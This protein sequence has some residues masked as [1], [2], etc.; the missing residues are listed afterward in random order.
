MLSL[1]CLELS[2]RL[3]KR[4]HS[5]S[6]DSVPPCLELGLCH[7]ETDSCKKANVKCSGKEEQNRKDDRS[8]AVKGK[9]RRVHMKN[10]NPVWQHTGTSGV[11]LHVVVCD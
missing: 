4:S 3:R 9:K 2:T 1:Y 8:H 10:L 7:Q 6:V 11:I 5:V